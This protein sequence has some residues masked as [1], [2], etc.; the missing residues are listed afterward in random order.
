MPRDVAAH[1]AAVVVPTRADVAASSET[2]RIETQPGNH[3]KR[4]PRPG[5]NRHPSAAAAFAEAHQVA[6]RHRRIQHPRAVE[7]EGNSPGTIITA[8]VKR[9]VTAAP[10]IWFAA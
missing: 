6:R 7:R 9:T 10:D 8:I 3:G 1:V 4:V 2:G 5:I